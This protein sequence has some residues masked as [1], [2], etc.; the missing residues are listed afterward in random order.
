VLSDKNANK[1]F[2]VFHW[3]AYQ[4]NLQQLPTKQINNSKEKQITAQQ[5]NTIQLQNIS[6]QFHMNIYKKRKE[7]KEY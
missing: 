7:N 4:Q 2:T 3:I 6:F 1:E 5:I